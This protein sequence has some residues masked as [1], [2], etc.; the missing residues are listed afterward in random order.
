ML[1][2]LVFGEGVINDA[3]SVV[4]LG[5][6]SRVF[7]PASR[8][9]EGSGG[10]PPGASGQG[11]GVILSFMYLLSTSM[12][13]GLVTGLAIAFLLRRFEGLG[14]HQVGARGGCQGAGLGVGSHQVGVRVGSPKLSGSK[15]GVPTKWVAGSQ[16]AGIRNKTVVRG[17]VAGTLQ[18]H[19]CVNRSSG[20]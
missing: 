2:S 10:A 19:R 13:L 7:P 14:A 11:M 4:L 12:V 16:E 3:T 8:G 17:Q 6:V 5:A 1:F 18:V 9:D 15:V 20:V